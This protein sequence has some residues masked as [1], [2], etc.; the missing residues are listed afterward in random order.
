[1]HF[2]L[3]CPPFKSHIAVFEALAAELLH[4]GHR[5][6]FL[7]N[8]GAE[9]EIAGHFAVQ[10][11]E[12][13]DRD[14]MAR[15]IER[16][17][18]PG[19]PVGILRTVH[20]TVI[21]S[22]ALCTHLPGHLQA[23]GVDAI[24]GDQM[25]PACGIVA[26]A[27]GLPLVSI[28]CALPV[29]TEP[30]I[31]LP[32]L[33]WPYDPTPKGAKRNRGGQRVSWLL[34]TEQRRLIRHWSA[35]YGVALRGEDL[36]SCLSD[37]ATIAQTVT[38][39]DFPRTTSGRHLHMVGPIRKP[40]PDESLPFAIDP[41]RP[42]VF[43][44]LG[45]L[46]GHRFRLFHAAALACKALGVQLLVAHCGG[47]D[48]RQQAQLGA[49]WVTDFAPQRAVLERADLC[50]THGGMNTVMDAL[51]FG[52]P[53]IALPIAFDQPG[54]AA[55]VAHHRVGLRLSP[56][57]LTAGRMKRAISTVLADPAYAER[58]QTIGRSIAAAGGLQAAMDRI[59]TAVAP[60]GAS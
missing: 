8:A 23:L 6:T 32:F 19:G 22:R 20:D 54:V 33:S 24:L 43:M 35:R 50:I 4:R 13:T 44:S 3:I 56:H 39:F 53:L 29:Q 1:M 37:I 31:P 21:L 48:A 30:A 17:S 11:V 28:A 27:L 49:D 7:V 42:F 12:G 60:A 55:R 14:Q 10:P 5:V 45:T 59:E 51:E 38:A 26:R 34:L 46:Q 58:A 9:H 18:K 41:A 25:E 57:W 16:A 52:T 2:A 40:Q 36:Q 47:L 15:I